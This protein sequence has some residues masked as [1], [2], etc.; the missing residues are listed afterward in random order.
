MKLIV[1][2]NQNLNKTNLDRF[3]LRYN[4]RIQFEKLFWSILPLN[5][6]ALFFEY[7]KS[8]YRPKKNK[9]FINIKN[10]YELYKNIK[11]VK[12]N[13]YFLNQADGYFKSLFIELI[14]RFKGCIILKKIEWYVNSNSKENFSK[15]ISR[16]YKFGF[17]FTIKKF[18]RALLFLLKKILL[19]TFYYKPDYL[20]I[21]NQK[22]E[23]ELKKKNIDNFIKVNSY[24]YYSF[25]KIKSKKNPKNYFVFLDSEI[26]NSFESKVLKNP[27]NFVDH[28]NY[29]KC[30]NNIFDNLSEKFNI[31]VKIAAHFR[32]SKKNCPINK[33]FY[34]DQ[35][36]ELIK[37]SKFVV[38]Q[39]SSTID[40]AVLLKKPI[41]L[42]NFKSFDSI[43]L[44]NSDTIKWYSNK[45]SLE[46][47]NIDS[48]YN[49]NLRNNMN[50]LLKIDRKKY[51]KFSQF[52]INYKTQK[53]S[54]LNQWDMIYNE[55]K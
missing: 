24:T 55:F 16:L 25:N 31:D 45:L 41:L 39:N 35:S 38:V 3:S 44:E 26:E 30:L 47:V 19:K 1:L 46:I 27:H 23:L 2:V 51:Q 11:K 14:M 10:Y 5:N 43:S 4:K 40:W 54:D 22:R 49:L 18:L 9:N 37:N 36:L 15:K 8:E 29:W 34:F 28:S 6:R 32:R 52:Y 53:S 17:S 13:T 42:L 50:S 48:N 12:K 33:K 21:E 20:I 7:E